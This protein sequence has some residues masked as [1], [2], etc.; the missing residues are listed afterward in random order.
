MRARHGLGRRF[1]PSAADVAGIIL[2]LCFAGAAEAREVT[3]SPTRQ[4]ADR[5]RFPSLGEASASLRDGDT[6][7]LLPGIYREALVLRAHRVTVIA[8]RGARIDGATAE[9]KAALV[10]KGDDTR[11]E[12]LECSGIA[13]PDR[14]GAC[15]RLEGR[16]L[17]LRDVHFHDS[18]EGLLTGGNPGI[19]RIES[20]LFERLGRDGQAH[21]LYIGGGRLEIVKSAI[22]SSKEE[23]HE[24]KSRARETLISDSVVASLDGESSRAVD[25]PHGGVVTIE[26]SVI[27]HGP[28]AANRDLIGFGVEGNL[29][30]VN[31]LTIRDSVLILERRGGNVLVNAR[32]PPGTVQIRGNLIVGRDAPMQAHDCNRVSLSRA[33]AG[34]PAKLPDPRR[35]SVVAVV[36]RS[37]ESLP[38][39]CR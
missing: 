24:V 27:A 8:E 36:G 22:L 13:V 18:E 32:T 35:E 25:L 6:L 15:I 11:V 28:S 4:S 33:D 26:R 9:G 17:T 16:N 39:A 30:P 31:R 5:G 19:V 2:L 37:L 1:R 7:R 38:A 12:G 14:N 3:V 10:I 29:H 21:G 34:L 20:S 23:G